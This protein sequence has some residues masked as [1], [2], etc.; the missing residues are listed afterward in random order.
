MHGMLPKVDNK[1]NINVM[2]K[3]ISLVGIVLLVVGL[4]LGYWYGSQSAYQGGYDKAVADTEAA[5]QDAAQKAADE[6]AQAANP[7]KTT[8]PL[9]GVQANPFEDAAKNL[10]PFSQ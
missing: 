1:P 3:N 9:E 6:A 5:Q 2:N 10:N 4:A 8:N 7:F